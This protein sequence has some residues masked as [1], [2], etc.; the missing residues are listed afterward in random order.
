MLCAAVTRGNATDLFDGAVDGVVVSRVGIERSELHPS[1]TQFRS[2][3]ADEAANVGADLT[4]RQASSSSSSFANTY[5][6]ILNEKC[7]K[8][9]V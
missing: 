2:R 1:L 4:I 9:T 7:S 3:V 6:T 8:Q 5:D